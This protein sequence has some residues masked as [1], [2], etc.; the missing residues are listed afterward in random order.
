MHICKCTH[1][2]SICMSVNMYVFIYSIS[3]MYR[4]WQFKINFPLKTER[5]PIL[6]RLCWFINSFQNI[7]IKKPICLPLIITTHNFQI[8][9]FWFVLLTFITDSKL[10]ISIEKASVFEGKPQFW[11]LLVWLL[12]SYLIFLN[13]I[14]FKY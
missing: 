1:A 12:R 7:N 2:V 13:F 5:I 8:I 3:R 6:Y 4:L 14:F 11:H 10:P 9:H